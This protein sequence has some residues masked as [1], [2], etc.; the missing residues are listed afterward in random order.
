MMAQSARQL[1]IATLLA[2]AVLLAAAG[3]GHA[4]T[5]KAGVV[6]VG[7]GVQAATDAAVR[8]LKDQVDRL[9]LGAKMTVG[10]YLDT[11][12]GHAAILPVLQRAQLIGGPRPLG[13]EVFQVRLDMQLKPVA[14][15]LS[16]VAA[17]RRARSPYTPEFVAR[18]VQLWS[19]RT[20]TAT[21]ISTG[22]VVATDV[23]VPAPL[24]APAPSAVA[25]R[26]ESVSGA[27]SASTAPVVV[28]A[29]ANPP[30]ASVVEAGP[31]TVAAARDN[32]AA[33]L[34]A[35]VSAVTLPGGRTGGDLVA[36]AGVSEA[37]RARVISAPVRRIDVTGE[38]DVRVILRLDRDGVFGAIRETAS[39]SPAPVVPADEAGW[40]AYRDPLLAAIPEELVGTATLSNVP[41]R[42][43]PA[44][45]RT[46]AFP[47]DRPPG[48]FFSGLDAGGSAAFAGTKLQTSRA[49]EADA[50]ALLRGQL[51]G[52]E[53][54]PGLTL[55]EMARRDARFGVALDRAVQRA[56]VYRV[57]YFEDGSAGVRV[58]TDPRYLWQDLVVIAQA[59]GLPAA[60]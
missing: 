43:A 46:L 31:E 10:Q 34:V 27:G 52:L 17:V 60:R 32:A 9:P 2:G 50:L 54:S 20:I 30:V 48:W 29:A 3:A 28:P 7:G 51:D 6:G 58:S 15:A 39:R 38:R 40:S 1:R 8:G 44:P 14:D 12:D 18:E 16:Q 19:G 49:A 5:P 55:G 11:I 13:A 42:E 33:G 53:L 25:V 47:Y 45:S 37:I 35:R 4:Q 26:V 23:P 24:P 56:R 59:A 22:E 21:G 41:S 57:E 36:V